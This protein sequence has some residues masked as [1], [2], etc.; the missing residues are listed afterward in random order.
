MSRLFSD[1]SFQWSKRLL[2]GGYGTSAVLGLPLT[3]DNGPSDL[4]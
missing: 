2:T 3:Y 4:T 1:R